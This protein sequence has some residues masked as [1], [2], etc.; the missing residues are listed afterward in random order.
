MS[1]ERALFVGWA[2][3]TLCA[4]LVVAF[5]F[6]QRARWAWIATCITAAVYAS[7]MFI[8]VDVGV[9]YLS[10]AV[11]MAVGLFLTARAFFPRGLPSPQG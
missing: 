3:F 2:A 7:T 6:W 9:W 10:S 8:S 1:D 4:T 5:P 11:V